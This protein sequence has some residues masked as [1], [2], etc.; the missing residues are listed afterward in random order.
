MPPHEM[1][2]IVVLLPGITGSVLKRNGKVVW[3]FSGGTIAGTLLTGGRSL[4]DALALKDDPSDREDVGDGIV[5][6][7]LAPDLHLLPGLWKID[8][9]SKVADTIL[10]KF[11]V[12]E[13]ENFFRYPYDWR[14]DNRVAANRLARASAGWLRR[15]R[16]SV[17]DAKLILVA[18]S[19]G[20]LVSRYFLEVLGGWR[21]TRALITFGTPYRGSINALDTLANGSRKGPFGL[22]DLSAL[23][24]SFTAVYQLLPIYPCYDAGDGTLVRVGETTGIPNLEA[25]KAK[26]A[27]AFHRE[28]EAAVQRNSTDPEYQKGRYAIRPIVGIGQQTG[29]SGRL[30]GTAVDILG[31][32]GGEDLS[33][34]GTV[35]RVSATPIE[36]AGDGGGMFAATKHA[37]LQNADA[38]GVHLEGV[39]GGL[40]LDLGRFRKAKPKA[41]REEK[42]KVSLAVED[43]YWSG[44]TVQVRARCE[45]EDAQLTATVSTAR[46]GRIA[47][48]EMVDGGD[49][50]RIA[51]FTP[52]AAGTYRVEVSGRAVEPAGDAFAVADVRS[53]GG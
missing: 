52:P 37:A 11:A 14:R 15:R 3:G 47:G 6:D 23:V 9:Y 43:V 53:G 48:V 2:D 50:W 29:Q 12:K 5:A 13:G 44:E 38:V 35:P 1:R 33:G 18:H 17:P 42:A 4:L 40:R 32:L 10:A 7:S 22:I 19:M 27:L 49:G 39:L 45:R 25:G 31:A 30:N 51:E 28:I 46:G 20:G 36:L 41:K 21:D 24:R 16:Q 34:D 8:G 26:A